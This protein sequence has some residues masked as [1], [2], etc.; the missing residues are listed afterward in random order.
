[1][2]EATRSQF[3][4]SLEDNW[5]GLVAR[6][7]SL[8]P[9]EQAVWLAR[10]GYARL[11][12]LLAHVIA[13]WDEAMPIISRLAAGQEVGHKEYDEDRFNAEAVARFADYDEAMVIAAFDAR[14]KQ[15]ITL[16]NELPD[17]ALAEP[18]L[19][20][21]LHVELIRHYQEHTLAAR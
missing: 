20:E 18:R 8:P 11:A 7:R 2:P 3:F 16:V 10:Q 21:R 1:M 12:D 6:F 17:S 4:D 14:C 13:W 15:W 5:G 9:H 19:A